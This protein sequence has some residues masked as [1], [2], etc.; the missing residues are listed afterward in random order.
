MAENYDFLRTFTIDGKKTNHLFQIAKVTIPFLNKENEFY[1][2][3]NTDGSHF[4]VTRLGNYTLQID[5]FVIKDNTKMSVSD[6]M[7]EL[8]RLC[9][10]DEP[11]PLVFDVFPDRYFNAIFS[12]AQEY[13]ATN[14][15]YT[16]L[17]LVFEVPDGLAHQIN[18]S[19][20]SN[21]YTS[22]TN[23]MLDS[24][25]NNTKKYMA[26]WVQVLDEKFE[27][28]NIVRA[29]FSNGT[30]LDE[31]ERNDHWLY[32]TWVS[33]RTLSTLKKGVSVGIS[34]Y[35]RI[36]KIDPNNK[37][38]GSLVL[39]E[40]TDGKKNGTNHF[41]RFDNVVND[42]FVKYSGTFTLTN[43]KTNG[44]AMS[45][46]IYGESASIDYSKPMIGLLPPIGTT[47]IDS[48]VGATLYS[49]SLDFGN[50]DYSGNPN[51][52]PKLDYSKLSK[53]NAN[54]QTPPA[55]VKDHGTYFEVDMDDPSASGI[56]RN[57]FIPLVARLQ[58]G[59]T[60]TISVNIMISD[61]MNIAKC[62]MYYTVYR[63]L[64]TPETL[65]PVVLFPTND[66]K[67]KFVRVS[68]TF[69]TPSDMSDGD[70][71]PYLQWYFPPDALGK[72][73]V[74]YDI[75][76]EEGSTATPYQPN[77]LDAPYYLSKVALGEN[78][79]DP[80][81]SFPIKTSAY[82]L[83]GVNMLEEFKIGQ[84]YTL[85]MKATKPASQTFWAYNGGNISLE[86]MTPVE[87]LVDVWTCSFTI[88][89]LDS[90]SPRLLSIYQT[91]QSTASAC[92]IDWLKIEKGDTRTPNIDYYKYRGLH[93]YPSN[94]PKEYAWEYDPSYFNSFNYVASEEGYADVVNVVNNGT[95]KAYPTFNFTMNG[96][97]GLVAVLNDKGNVLQFGNPEDVD[98]TVAKRMEMGVNQTFWGNSLPSGIVVNTNFDTV[99]KNMNSNPGTPN[100]VQ[101]SFSMTLDPDAITPV[102]QGVGDIGVWHGP[103]FLLPITAPSTNDRTQN[104]GTHIRFG[105]ENYD[106][107]QRGRIEYAIN[108]ENGSNAMT[109]IVRD[110]S[111]TANEIVLEMWYKHKRL[112]MVSLDRRQF[113]N[114]FF[115]ASMERRGSQLIWR[116]AQIK[117]L[118][119]YD[120]V[121]IDKQYR[122]VWN[123]E[124]N[125]TTKFTT[126]GAWMMRYSNTYHVLMKVTDLKCKWYDT[127][128]YTDIKNYFQ[129]GDLVTID[130]ASRALLINGVENTELNIV[131]NQWEAFRVDLGSSTFQPIVSSWAN[132]P[133]VNVELRQTYL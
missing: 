12:G 116:L 55:Y 52:L 128:Y 56:A 65:R 90:G 51:L 68:K 39:E 61:E 1:N 70:F 89:K 36:N 63:S 81:V 24:E 47:V 22:G 66:N 21:V 16:P 125:D 6:A 71:S 25:F 7:D 99:Y 49:N 77:L 76:I 34:V 111:R 32:K 10:T 107:E 72:Y 83:Y 109:F 100:V 45:L 88:L 114:S 23:L 19:G 13:D 26:S 11:K 9:N 28:S 95:Y 124:E 122:F 50:Y 87:G 75:K 67:N 46:G 80:T 84:R 27:G 85:T 130:V 103:T 115:E 132:K 101:G 20:F 38:A 127:P 57:V 97:N 58:K 73:C 86:R 121:V 33:N 133:D 117:S 78:I 62:P 126:V 17:S 91:P 120:N 54:I 43:E 102:F 31:E 14:L 53:T 2:V 129:D 110:S 69:T 42:K 40:F 48:I 8:K 4:R 3:G 30:P 118:N 82:R 44:I 105:F 29:D 37:Y 59:K 94:N 5:G 106:K 98:G 108:D 119:K 41:V 64:P 113:K 15:D 123:L 79:A 93:S 92:Q 131:G 35:V 96:E 112:N 18:P 60:Y 74:G 104:F